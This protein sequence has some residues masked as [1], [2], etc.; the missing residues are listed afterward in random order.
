MYKITLT[1]GTS[2]TLSAQDY[3]ELSRA[4]QIGYFSVVESVEWIET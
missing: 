3:E 4:N 1:D 2:Y